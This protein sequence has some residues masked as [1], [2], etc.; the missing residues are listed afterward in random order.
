[1]LFERKGFDRRE[2]LARSFITPACGTGP[3]TLE[4]GERVMRLARE[5][6]D[7]VREEYGLA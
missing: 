7:Q 4:V 2:L 5:L 6:S 3:L 1:M